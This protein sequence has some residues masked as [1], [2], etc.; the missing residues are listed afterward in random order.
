MR[1]RLLLSSLVVVSVIAQAA[2]AGAEDPGVIQERRFRPQHELSLAVGYLPLG[3]LTKGVTGSIGYTLHLDDHLAWRMAEV[4][5]SS[6]VKSSIR[7]DLQNNYGTPDREFEEPVLLV[8]SELIWQALYG[9]E[10]LFNRGVVWTGT[11]VH[12]GG[13]GVMLRSDTQSKLRPAAVI[14]LGMK[15]YVDESLALRLEVRDML[16]VKELTLPD[17]VLWLSVAATW[18]VGVR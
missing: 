15:L 10:S 12:L 4:G 17:Q 11:T 5:V 2:P 8:T 1:I 13:G 9:R 3:A 14:G 7:K 16:V 18:A 6:G